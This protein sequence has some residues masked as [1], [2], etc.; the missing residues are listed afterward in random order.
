MFVRGLLFDGEL[1][2]FESRYVV[3]PPRTYLVKPLYIYLGPVTRYVMEGILP[4]NPPIR[5][6]EA[7]LVRVIEASPG[8]KSNYAGKIAIVK[9]VGSKGVLSKDLDG[10]SAN[11]T[12]IYE[13]YIHGFSSKARALYTLQPFLDLAYS[14]IKDSGD[15]ILIIGCDLIGIATG[16]VA[17]VKGLSYN[18]YCRDNYGIARKLGLNTH[19]N[20]GDLNPEYDSIILSTPHSSDM[21]NILENI[22]TRRILLNPLYGIRHVYI[23]M[24]TRLSI[25]LHE[26]RNGII[27]DNNYYNTL[28]MLARYVK[29][30]GLGEGEF[31]KVR[32]L[33]PPKGLGV[34]IS[35]V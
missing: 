35:L 24:N 2:V 27:R 9:P 10:L 29:I 11:Y 23:G 4:F 32:G 28:H 31:E 13:D 12:Y 7:G 16:L 20:I 25:S 21:Y 34:I 18:L 1:R 14:F 3:L 19:R 6:G 22:K 33:L 15:N 30:I 5:L 17:R 26:L 8:I